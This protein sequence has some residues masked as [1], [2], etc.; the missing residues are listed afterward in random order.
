MTIIS[1]QTRHHRP[2]FAARKQPDVVFEVSL[3]V[4]IVEYLRM[5]LDLK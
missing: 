2:D 1:E 5:L 4:C 3:N